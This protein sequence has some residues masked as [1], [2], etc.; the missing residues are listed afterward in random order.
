MV[1][2]CID[3]S[4]PARLKESILHFAHRTAMN[5]DVLGDWLVGELVARGLKGFADLYE[6]EAEELADLEKA[7][8]IGHDRA[9]KLIDGLA[10]ARAGNT[11]AGVLHA[12]GIP[13]LG[14]DKADRLAGAMPDLARI[15]AATETELERVPGI[16]RRTAESI[17]AFFADPAHRRLAVLAAGA[18]PGGEPAPAAFT[19]ALRRFVQRTAADVRGLGPVLAG[20][21][22]DLELV[23]RPGDLYALTVAQLVGVPIWIKLGKKSADKVIG[24]LDRSK[25]AALGRLV[26]GLGIRH[27]GARTADLLAARFGSLGALAEA[28]AEE[29]EAVEEVGPIIAESVRAFFAAS[30]NRALIERLREAGVDPVGPAP[31]GPAAVPAAAAAPPALAGKTFVLTGTL[32]TMT[33][34]EAGAGIRALG[35]RVVGSVSSKTDYVVV[36]DSPGSKL[37][38]ARR[39][40]IEILEEGD[41]KRLLAGGGASG[42]SSM[43]AGQGSEAPPATRREAAAGGERRAAPDAEGPAAPAPLAG[44][45]FVL[46]GRLRAKQTDVRARIEALGGEVA[47]SVDAATDYLVAGARPGAKR[48]EAARRGVRVLGE[49]DLQ[50]MLVP[51]GGANADR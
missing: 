29:L 34:D 32:S 50:E 36:G 14:R 47:G 25:N 13:G 42:G 28:S 4:C 39:L 3:A 31:A 40:E 21:L 6:L 37:E 23:R 22:I 38:K 5:I 17:R 35:G 26:Y 48:D 12:L 8:T 27:V 15:A 10:R 9:V 44:T 46:A 33:R 7:S 24:A 20:R 45:T 19:D 41:F 2:R 49:T 51:V 11:P 1:A 18:L 30:G 16:S 43:A